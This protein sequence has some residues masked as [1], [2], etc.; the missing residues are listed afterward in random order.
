MSVLQVIG[1]TVFPVRLSPG[2]V[3]W[4]GMHQNNGST[5]RA[6]TQNNQLV[7]GTV[8]FSTGGT[9]NCYTSAS[10][11]GASSS[12]VPAWPA[13]AQIVDGTPTTITQPI[14]GLQFGS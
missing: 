14:I 13:D 9:V 6:I 2:Y 1:V 7:L 11:W 4:L 3:Y 8:D 5:F 10:D 12:Y